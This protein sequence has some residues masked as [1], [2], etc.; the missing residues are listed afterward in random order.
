MFTDVNYDIEWL[1]CREVSSCNA[2]AD[3]HCKMDV[4][5]HR[6]NRIGLLKFAPCDALAILLNVK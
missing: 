1:V 4:T 3:F 6:D 5:L 2:L